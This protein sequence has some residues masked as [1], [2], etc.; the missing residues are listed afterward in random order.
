LQPRTSE[1][2]AKK[3]GVDADSVSVKEPP[4]SS[5]NYC[6]IPE[7]QRNGTL[8]D[9]LRSLK[10]KKGQGEDSSGNDRT[11]V[12]RGMS[13]DLTKTIVRSQM[14]IYYYWLLACTTPQGPKREGVSKVRAVGR[15]RD[16][17]VG[18]NQNNGRVPFRATVEL[19]CVGCC[20]LAT[21]WF[22]RIVGGSD[23]E[24]EACKLRTGAESPRGDYDNYL[25]LL[26]ED[27]SFSHSIIFLHAGATNEMFCKLVWRDHTIFISSSSAHGDGALGRLKLASRL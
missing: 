7:T 18:G 2:R 4:R 10:T 5:I 19:C 11:Q 3:C 22:N 25:V 15:W 20:S 6:S 9:S 1:L 8:L 17:P 24:R 21:K 14:I 16:A 12:G 27:S 26:L 13:D 23:R